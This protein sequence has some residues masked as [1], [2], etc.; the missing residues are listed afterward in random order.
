MQAT[1]CGGPSHGEAEALGRR[2]SVVA[3]RGLSSYGLFAP[4]HVE[5]SQT[6]GRTHVL[7]IDRQMLNHWTIREVL[8]YSSST[9]TCC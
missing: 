9:F 8:I 6:R 4:W 1:H 2:A 3:M 5:S 7:C